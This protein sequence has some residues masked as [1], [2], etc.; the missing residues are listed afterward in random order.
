MSDPD[1]QRLHPGIAG[2][3]AVGRDVLE[4]ALNRKLS[5]SSVEFG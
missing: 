4:I 1:V 5:A 3:Q 2:N